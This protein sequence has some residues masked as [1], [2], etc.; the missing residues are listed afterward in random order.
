MPPLPPLTRSLIRAW[1]GSAAF[2]RG[3]PYFRG[4]A[5]DRPL[6]QGMALK[7][8][9]AGTQ[10]KPYRVAI[11]F[12]DHGITSASCTCQ[13]GYGGRCK[14]VAAL[15]FAWLDQPDSFIER[16]TV[17]A[18]LESMSRTE[19]VALVKRLFTRQPSL[20]DLIDLP[21]AGASTDHPVDPR[22][23][24]RQVKGALHA[25][26][27]EFGE[28]DIDFWS[29][30]Q[31]VIEL[32][33]SCL[34][35]QS[36][37][38][39]V[40]VFQET[41]QVII[42]DHDD[43]S[44]EEWQVTRVVAECVRGLGECLQQVQDGPLRQAIIHTLFKVFHQDLQRGGI[45]LA[46]NAPDWIIKL[47]SAPEKRMV[48]GWVQSALS[49]SE[50]GFE[51]EHLGGFLLR[52][53]EDTLDD[54]SYLRI[55]HETG[56][57]LDL[58][59]RLLA[60]DRVSE[61]ADAVREASDWEL[62]RLADLFLLH[63]QEVLASQLVVFRLQTSKD[64]RLLEWLLNQA[65]K[66]GRLDEALD[67][68]RQIFWLR[69]TLP[70]YQK[71]RELALQAKCWPEQ[72]VEVMTRLE[73]KE[74]FAL[75]TEI[76]TYEKEIDQ[77]LGFLNRFHQQASRQTFWEG[78]RVDVNLAETA[79]GTHPQVAIHLYLDKINRLI[80]LRG[81]SNYAAAARLLIRIKRLYERQ[82]A[83]KDW[84]MLIAQLRSDNSRLP[85]LQDELDQ[86]EL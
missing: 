55:C 6:L 18:Q 86:A 19:L 35:V 30:M 8:F 13:V 21:L 47:T 41:I 75:L 48:A 80:R 71:L 29:A 74:N 3:E 58:V 81:R 82:D 43:L 9:C 22:Q 25:S 57:I 62:L 85:A 24:R 53:A 79:E 63:H 26:I 12:D 23:V 34:A 69:P 1:V 54:E 33:D 77:A 28:G 45:G 51:R 5:I 20:E 60:L 27:R 61:A 64:I 84:R 52:L 73:Q 78:S 65:H 7:A 2:E 68:A 14:H 66:Q 56:R 40:I 59:D 31:P 72:K 38:N 76:C 36:Y 42:N 37:T 32:A 10:P 44:D 4:G 67:Y 70:A 15:L 46:E 17:D 39:A 16:P 83:I 11:S 49:E 50:M